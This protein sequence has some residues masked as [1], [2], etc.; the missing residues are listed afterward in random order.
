MPR[1]SPKTPARRGG[2]GP[3][4]LYGPILTLGLLGPQK[5]R[6]DRLPPKALTRPDPGRPDTR[7]PQLPRRNGG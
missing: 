3:F 5:D 6:G 1:K 7:R 2:T 4:N